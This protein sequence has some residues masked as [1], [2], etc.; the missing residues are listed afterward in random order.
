MRTQIAPPSKPARTT[1][2]LIPAASHVAREL[3]ALSGIMWPSVDVPEEQ[4]ETLS[5]TV[6]GSPVTRSA[7]LAAPTLT[8]QLV[9]TTAPSANA[10]PPTSATLS[11]GVVTSAKAT[12]LADRRRNVTDSRIAASLP[13]RRESVEKTQTARRVTT[14][15]LALAPRTSLVTHTPAATR[16]ARATQT[17]TLVK[18]A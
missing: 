5:E 14:V 13:V 15:L 7:L 12:R 1:S 2:A 9:K 10:N 8:A 6:A 11:P 18:R 3:T 16:S 17:A 4:L